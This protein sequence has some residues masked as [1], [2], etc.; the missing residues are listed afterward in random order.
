MTGVELDAAAA[1]VEDTLLEMYT[2]SQIWRSALLHATFE[3]MCLTANH[4]SQSNQTE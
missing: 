4:R 1:W 2:G 3:A